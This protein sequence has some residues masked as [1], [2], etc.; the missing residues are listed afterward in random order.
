MSVDGVGS[1]NSR[2]RIL[3]EER[4]RDLDKIERNYREQVK[5]TQEDRDRAL[6]E[7]Y[8]NQSAD[9]EGA[10]DSSKRRLDEVRRQA[11]EK[12]R[13]YQISADR[14]AEQAKRQYE[15]KANQLKESANQLDAQRKYLEKNHAAALKKLKEEHEDLYDSKMQQNRRD[16]QQMY[17]AHRGEVKKLELLNNQEI[18]DIMDE[19]KHRIQTENRDSERQLQ[20]LREKRSNDT[21]ALEQ[22]NN[23]VTHSYEHELEHKRAG[24]LAR[25]VSE[26]LEFDS[27]MRD[28]TRN[29]DRAIITA[30]RKGEQKLKEVKDRYYGELRAAQKDGEKR[31]TDTNLKT[32]ATIHRLEEDF[33]AREHVAQMNYLSQ[34]KFLDESRDKF[35]E[36]RTK[37]N[38]K[39]KEQVDADKR[40]QSEELKKK[41]QDSIDRKRAEI[42]QT[43]NR[44]DNIGEKQVTASLARNL[45]ELGEHDNKQNDPFY[46]VQRIGAEMKDTSQ[47]VTVEIPVAEHEQSNIRVTLQQGFL[48]VSG[49]RKAENTIKHNDGS[50]TTT[51]AFQTYTESFPVTGKLLM[52]QMS[53]QYLDGKL[54]F[55]IPRG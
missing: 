29:T 20:A 23:H 9:I 51:N 31:V 18:R 24:Y 14:M 55:K 42:Q 37:Q 13:E 6:K 39:L 15:S 43:L 2:R 10:E 16:S 35:I 25:E 19:H 3:E 48:T 1:Y 17:A 5:K 34:R 47:E 53:R 50:K 26:E 4:A 46:N 41:Y 11:E 54:I 49:S 7:I 40:L 33:K 38:E 12:I 45:K 8:E 22:E 36:Q 32:H 30:S 52:T 27:R 28:L 21:A 44:L